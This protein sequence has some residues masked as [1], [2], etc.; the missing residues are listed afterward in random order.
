LYSWN[1]ATFTPS[2]PSGSTLKVHVYSDSGSGPVLIP[3]TV[4]PSNAAGFSSSPI[5]LAAVSTSTYPNLE[6]GV[7]L[8]KGSAGSSPN[9]DGWSI[10]YDQGPTPL[11]SFPFSLRGAKTIGTTAGGAS[12]YK[13]SQSLTSNTGSLFSTSTLEWDSYTPTV[14][15]TATGYDIAG[16]CTPTPWSVSAGTSVF[17]ALY[18][19]AHSTNSL[20]VT[21][22]DSATG[23]TINSATVAL[24]R[25]GFSSTKTT[26]LCG[27]AFYSGLSAGTVSGG[28]TYTAAVSKTGYQSATQTGVVVSGASSVSVSLTPL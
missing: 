3:D 16:A 18:M 4:I 6:L 24:T 28:N 14:D 26:R 20:L 8:N 10:D 13:F 2:I 22:K 7:D 9:L 19:F 17:V 25:S 1:S 21:V 23:A 11:P 15:S 5:S 27:Q 12:I